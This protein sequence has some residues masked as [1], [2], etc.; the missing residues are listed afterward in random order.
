MNQDKDTVQGHNDNEEVTAAGEPFSPEI[1]AETGSLEAD[2]NGEDIDKLKADLAEIN[3]KFLRTYSEFD[4]YKKRTQ[5]ERIDLI[6]TANSDV[7]LAML[8]VIDD[9]ERAFKA[10][11][12]FKE[13]S[14]TSD[15]F[16]LIYLKLLSILEQK[17]LKKMHSVGEEF[18]VD[19]HDAITNVP[20]P[21]PDMVGKVID[22]A[23]CG[24][25][26]NDKVIRHAKVVVGN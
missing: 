7:I 16:N 22:E 8:P 15:G 10:A 17:G 3:D 14:Q 4:N 23:D 19:L 26:L 5:R 21:S 20:A 25:F 11:E 6:K 13:G 9:F 2:L 24:Y 12:K 1:S 18:N